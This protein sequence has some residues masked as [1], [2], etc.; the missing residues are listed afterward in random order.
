EN[1]A[2]IDAVVFDKTGTLT[3]GKPSVTA[4]KA[5]EMS[6]KDL[7]KVTAEV[8]LISEHHL[9]QTIVKE[10]EERRITL[11]NEPTDFAEEKEHGLYA[12]VNTDKDVIGNRKLL[13]KSHIPLDETIDQYA[14]QEEKAGNTAIFV[15]V[16]NKVAGIVSI[17]DQIR[18]EA[19][20]TIRKLKAAGVKETIMLTGD[21]KH[22]SE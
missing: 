10:A 13:Q 1:F 7:L 6:E 16:N 5:F 8:E 3:Q 9:G 4:I 12:T 15:G 14:I 20:G 19:S 22:T 21:N 11:T 18:P 2:K 17:A